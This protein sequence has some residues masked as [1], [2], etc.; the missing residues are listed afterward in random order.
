MTRYVVVN[1]LGHTVLFKGDPDRLTWM[2]S[3]AKPF[4]LLPLLKRSLDLRYS[5]TAGEL[6][7]LSSSHLA[8]PQH[9]AAFLSI[10]QKT[11]IEEKSLILPPVAPSGRISYHYWRMH[12]GIPQKR[13]HPCAG[14]HVAIMLLQRELTGSTTGYEQVDSPAQ[15]E[16]LRYIE[17]YT[18]E[19][20][21][22]ETDNCGIPTYGISMYSLASAYQ[23]LACCSPSEDAFRLINAFHTAPVMVEGDGCLSTILCS[24][25]GLIAK[26]GTNYL[27][28][29]ASL[30]QRLG[31]AVISEEGWADIIHVL[32][33]LLSETGLFS[34]ELGH[35]LNDISAG[36]C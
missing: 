30:E 9:V 15:Q 25:R 35:K 12:C 7:L 31:I 20:P 17:A 14:N 33:G 29:L 8:Q 28:A 4:Q 5:L 6:T 27:L 34:K 18:G 3:T 22:L 23:R 26:T 21:A 19:F 32:P 16:I 2:H 36:N 10:L 1:N 13:Y 11:G 24:S